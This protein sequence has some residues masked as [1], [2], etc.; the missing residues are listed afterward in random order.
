MS[1]RPGITNFPSASN[2]RAPAGASTEPGRAD[3]DDD[4]V[5]YED[6]AADKTVG[7]GAVPYRSAPKQSWSRYRSDALAGEHRRVLS[8][9]L[10]SWRLP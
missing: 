5:F 1:T 9:R 2:W 3:C 4:A 8:E 7:V 10:A 6:V